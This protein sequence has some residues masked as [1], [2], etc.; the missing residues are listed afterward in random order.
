MNA[1]PMWSCVDVVAT[2][3]RPDRAHF[4]GSGILES[5]SPFKQG[6][7]AWNESLTRMCSLVPPAVCCSQGTSISIN[8][9]CA[10]ASLNYADDEES[11]LKKMLIAD[12]S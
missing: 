7:A 5:P 11:D 12:A 10:A 1:L 8:H 3:P 2:G 4:T 9:Y 6:H